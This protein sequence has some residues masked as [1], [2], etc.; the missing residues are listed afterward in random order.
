[1]TILQR[2]E[3]DWQQQADELVA[4]ASILQ[5]DFRLTAGPELTGDTEPDTA[6]LCNQSPCCE[7]LE[8]IAAVHVDLPT[9]GIHLQ[10]G[11]I[12]RL[13]STSRFEYVE[14]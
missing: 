11:Y 9:E 4:L 8:C 3:D 2:S 1:M 10:V 13:A 6:A 7:Q 5:H 12:Q 14:A